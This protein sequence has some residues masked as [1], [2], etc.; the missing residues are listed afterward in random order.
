MCKLSQVSPLPRPCKLSL[1]RQLS[2]P[3]GL[4]VQTFAYY[5]PLRT[6]TCSVSEFYRRETCFNCESHTI[7]CAYRYK[8]QGRLTQR[9][10][11]GYS[12]ACV[13]HLRTKGYVN[14]PQSLSPPRLLG[15]CPGLCVWD[16]H[17]AIGASSAIGVQVEHRQSGSIDSPGPNLE[18]R[19]GELQRRERRRK[20]H[21]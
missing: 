10:L 14:G 11:R 19:G 6:H 2:Q 4:S 7:R 9:F 5:P 16:A 1:V 8:A 21:L 13:P 12:N 20:C 17:S 3:G 18:Y 15:A